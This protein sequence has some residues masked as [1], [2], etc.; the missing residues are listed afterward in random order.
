[1]PSAG[2]VDQT[3]YLLLHVSE[4]YSCQEEADFT[5]QEGLSTHHGNGI[6]VRY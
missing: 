3:D 1:M 4:P 6:C 2:I 5:L